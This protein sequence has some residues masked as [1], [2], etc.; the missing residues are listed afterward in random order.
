MM[1][2][3]VCA[4]DGGR[5]RLTYAWVAI[6]LSYGFGSPPVSAQ[7][8]APKMPM[9]AVYEDGAEARWL[10]KPVL[11]ARLLDAME[12]LSTWTFT[13]DG[14]MTLAETP[15]KEGK[16]SL[17]IR[18]TQNLGKVG[19]AGEWEDL[20]A[21][22]KF[23]GEDWSHYNRISIW[24]YPD[25]VGAPAISASLVL[26]NEGTHKLPDRYNEG[27]HESI[28]LKNH[29]WNQVVWEI[30]PLSRDK[31]TELEFAYSLPKMLP[32]PGDQTILYLDQL[33]LQTVVADH[34]EGWD[35]DRGRIAFSHAGY[36]AGATKT[37]I[38][39]EL[40]ARE[41]SVLEEG[42]GKTILTKQVRQETTPLGN[43]SILDF[44]ELQGPG[45][46]FLRAGESSTRPFE[47]GAEAW[48]GE[49]LESD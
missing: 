3:S 13:G 4:R 43:F 24:V 41:F 38:A 22:R 29:E 33:E 28:I 44:S 39:S 27:R 21:D 18:S 46:Y 40:Q 36:T 45:K 49:H 25:V 32:D 5:K 14:D 48:R 47:I 2:E 9:Q 26:H 19:G 16:H 10:K 8:Q 42:T 34:V 17:R 30:A 7:Q 1:S 11:E 31:V 6:I 23:P 20:I 35:V 12:D 37:A 15:V